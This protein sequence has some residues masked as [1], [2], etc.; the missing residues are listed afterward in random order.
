MNEKLFYSDSFICT[1]CWIGIWRAPLFHIGNIK[2]Q[3]LLDFIFKCIDW[4]IVSSFVCSGVVSIW[5]PFLSLYW[6]SRRTAK[7][8]INEPQYRKGGLGRPFCETF[9]NWDSFWFPFQPLLSSWCDLWVS[10]AIVS[11]V[12]ANHYVL[13]QRIQV[14]YAFK[15]ILKNLKA[16]GHLKTSQLGGR[17]KLGTKG[18]FILSKLSTL[19]FGRHC[20][21]EGSPLSRTSQSDFLIFV[22]LPDQSNKPLIAHRKQIYWWQRWRQWW[23]WCGWGF[24]HCC[25]P[26]A[27][28]NHV[29]RDHTVASDELHHFVQCSC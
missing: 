10:S 26:F 19:V 11:L 6:R 17:L 29:W 22:I 14:L 27:A 12:T 13:R 25:S 28:G 8:C 3:R 18:L 23:R 21:G 16:H 4:T 9:S 24:C 5:C 1:Y 2:S 15:K 20:L 7:F